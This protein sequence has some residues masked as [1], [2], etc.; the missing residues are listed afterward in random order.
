MTAAVRVMGNLVTEQD[1]DLVGRTWRAV[2][3]G[4]ER[5]DRRPLFGA[6]G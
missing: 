5:I 6:S 3:R 2:G 4:A 1:T